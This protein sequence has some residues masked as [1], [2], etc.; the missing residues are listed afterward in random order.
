M[1]IGHLPAGYLLAKSLASRLLGAAREM[2]AFVCAALLGAV[3]PDVDLLYFYGIDHRQHHHHTYWTHLP[4][5]WI[6]LI[7]AAALWM[8]VQRDKLAP[9]LAMIFALNGFAHLLLDSIAGHIR[10][11][12]PFVDRPFSM[13]TVSA[14]YRP[15]WLN[16]VLH[17]TFLLETALLA[18]AVIVYVRARQRRS[19]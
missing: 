16:F 5:V 7:I 9:V 10:W 18:A 11:L 4:L 17:W 3:F 8:R 2:R 12:A 13:F 1:I 15:W 19:L 6:G 14:A